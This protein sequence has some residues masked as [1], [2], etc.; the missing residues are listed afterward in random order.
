M[1]R[2]LLSY[3]V[4]L[5]VLQL[6]FAIGAVCGMLFLAVLFVEGEAV[7]TIARHGL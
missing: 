5:E 6:T 1:I 3:G 4:K 7:L 2:K